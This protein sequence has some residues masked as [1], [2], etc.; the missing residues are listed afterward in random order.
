MSYKKSDVGDGLG[1]A[2]DSLQLPNEGVSQAKFSAD[3][4]NERKKVGLFTRLKR[5]LRRQ[6]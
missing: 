1:F 3:A 6:S 5:A 4:D 2:R